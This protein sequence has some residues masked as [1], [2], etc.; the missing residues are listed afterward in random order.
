MKNGIQLFI[1]ALPQNE[2]NSGVTRC[3]FHILI[4]ERGKIY[5]MKIL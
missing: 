4:K 1:A 3:F 2:K 5:Q